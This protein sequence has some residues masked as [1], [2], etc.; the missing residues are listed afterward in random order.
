MIKYY[1][2]VYLKDGT[3]HVKPFDTR[4]EAEDCLTKLRETKWGPK[5]DLT[6]IVK[7]DTDSAW[8]KAVK[9]YWI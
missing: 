4:Q 1:L 6:R 5:L 7:K 8:F 2:V 9:G 3:I